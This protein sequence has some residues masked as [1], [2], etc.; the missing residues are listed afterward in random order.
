MGRGSATGRRDWMSAGVAVLAALSAGIVAHLAPRALG[1][2]T[3]AD[4]LVDTLVPRVP[5]YLLELAVRLVGPDVSADAVGAVA[6]A[7]ALGL[8]L[9]GFPLARAD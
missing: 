6:G 4:L 2:P 9:L 3:V 7:L 8:I 1:G 5:L